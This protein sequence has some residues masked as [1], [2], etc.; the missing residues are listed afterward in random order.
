[1]RMVGIKQLR[2]RYFENI[3]SSPKN[4]TFAY[5]SLLCVS[6]QFNTVCHAAKYLSIEIVFDGN[7]L[8]FMI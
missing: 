7:E 8:L 6:Y 2:V 3:F 4:N 5:F 1:M